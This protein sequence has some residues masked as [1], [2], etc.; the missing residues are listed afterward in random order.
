MA[1]INT[2]KLVIGTVQLGKR[3][4]VTNFFDKPTKKKAYNILAYAY[5][6]NIKIFDTAPSYFSEKIL[7]DF[8]SAHGIKNDIKVLTKIN[9]IK[10]QKNFQYN[11]QKEVENSIK[12]LKYRIDTLFLHQPK[13]I[14][15]FIKNLDFFLKLK[16]NFGIKNLG[17]SVYKPS[18][19][20]KTLLLPFKATY[21]FPI[22][23]ADQ[24]FL[25]IKISK[26]KTFA[27]SIFLQ[28]LLTNIKIYKRNLPSDLLKSHRSYHDYLKSLKIDPIVLS[29]SF[30][31]K[32]K[33]IGFFLVGIDNTQQLESI[34]K[35]N[36]YNNV[37]IKLI[38]KLNSF[39]YKKYVDP[40]K[41]S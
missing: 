2:D 29:L 38:N 30:I 13:D 25:N 9:S 41:W 19:I 28:G 17:F 20:E 35:A 37:D 18:E 14:T 12:N 6:N 31:N 32:L 1:T 23:I 24:R 4:G 39:F 36:L 33:N 21:Q 7:G 10:K 5:Q 22:N 34:V 27:R 16:K 26:N 11:I 15:F 8:I 3:D 40:R